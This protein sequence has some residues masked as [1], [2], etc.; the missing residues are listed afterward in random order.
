MWEEVAKVAAY[1]G[2]KLGGDE[3]A[4]DRIMLTDE[5]ANELGRFWEEACAEANNQLK[6]MLA[7]ASAME[8][9]YEAKLNVSNYYDTTL[10]ESVQTALRGYFIAA[11]MARWCKF[12]NKAEAGL[13]ATEATMMM[14]DVKQKLYYRKRPHRPNRD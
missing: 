9:D 1:T 11:I 4:Y 10:N 7:E 12:A 2:D 3:L 5:D 8:D 13:Y 14:A 6:E